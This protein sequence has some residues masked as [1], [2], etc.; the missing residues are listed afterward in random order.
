MAQPLRE[1]TKQ[2]VMGWCFVAA[3]AV[4]KAMTLT[5]EVEIMKITTAAALIPKLDRIL[6]THGLPTKITSDNVPPYNSSELND[7]FKELISFI[8]SLSCGLK[9]MGRHNR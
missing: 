9:L 5:P 6:P 1:L 7:Y 3:H 4:P 2:G 8:L